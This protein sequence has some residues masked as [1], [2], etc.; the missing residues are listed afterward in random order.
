M[1]MMCAVGIAQVQPRKS[2]SPEHISIDLSAPSHPL[3]HFWEEMFG[4]GRAILTLRDSYRRDL[5]TTRKATRIKYVRFHGIFMDEVG[6][7]N[8]DAQGNPSYDFSY[9]DQIYDG[10]LENGVKPFIELT[11]MPKQL[12]AANNLHAFWY[13]QNVA[14]PKDWDRWRDLIHAFA[15]HLVDRYGIDEVSSW[16]FEVWN[17]P[18]IDFWTGEPKQSTYFHLYDVTAQALKKVS[19][20]LRVGGPSTA[21]AA[22]VS[23]FIRHCEENK[24]PVDFVSSHVYGNDL[25]EDVFHT[26]ELIPRDQM[27]CRAIRKVHDEI[28]ASAMPKLPLIWSEFNA[29]YKNEVAVTD[30]TYMGPWLATTIRQC[31]GYVDLMSYWTFSDVF[32]EQGVIKEPF[33]G[34]FGIIGEGG[35]VKPAYNA[36][37]LLDK[38]G[39]ERIDSQSADTLVTRRKNGDIVIAVWNLVNPESTGTA[40]EFNLD[41]KSLGNRKHATIYRLDHQHGDVYLAYE[42]MGRP[43]Y[44]THTQNGQLLQA[45]QLEVPEQRVIQG[46]LNLEIP[47]NGLVV[48]EIK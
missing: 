29:S 35:I 23:D 36:F 9:I 25:S 18:N 2:L 14:P 6:L 15:Q 47:V 43:R 32:E 28:G 48:I 31:D 4:S 12:A 11:F 44:P 38:L 16:Y 20:R 46:A 7:Y 30:S 21:Q 41:F 5:R 26:H 10:L 8:E 24:I 33:Y 45:A 39:D 3:P 13:K 40:R 37:L 42:K 22:W 34:G 27:V 19:P 1:L 17:E